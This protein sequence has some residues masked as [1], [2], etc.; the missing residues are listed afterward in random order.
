MLKKTLLG[1][2]LSGAVLM[3]FTS[4][5]Q[6]QARVYFVQPKDG[7]TVTSPV[8]VQFAVDGMSI[9]PAGTM[10]E[11]TGHHHVLIDGKPLPKGTVIP[12]ND[13][14]LHYGKGQTEADIRLPPGD[15]TLTLQFGDGAHRSYGP[16]MS[17]T[18]KIHVQ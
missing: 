14:S 17:Q 11:G 7:A 5:A 2:V 10:T 18:I 12:A 8:H 16:E 3:S 9:S 13:T 1:A 6:A 15:H 4:A